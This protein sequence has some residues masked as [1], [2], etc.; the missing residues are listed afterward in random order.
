[1]LGGNPKHPNSRPR[2]ETLRARTNSLSIH[3]IAALC[4]L[5]VVLIAYRLLTLEMIETGGDAVGKWGW[6]RT[7][8]WDY[9]LAKRWNH[10][11]ARLGINGWSLLTQA[12]FGTNPAFYYLPTLFI[13]GLQVVFVFLFC[14]RCGGLMAAVL[15]CLLLIFHPQMIRSGVQLLPAAFSG[16]YIMATI[17]FLC[18]CFDPPSGGFAANRTIAALFFFAAYL[19]KVTNLF[20]LP[21]FVIAVW[22]ARRDFRD[23]VKFLGLLFAL[24][25]AEWFF[26][27]IVVGEYPLGRASIASGYGSAIDRAQARMI[28]ESLETTMLDLFVERYSVSKLGG[29]LEAALFYTGLLAAGV[30]I[31][32]SWRIDNA[33]S[34]VAWACIVFVL[35][36]GLLIGKVDPLTPA[37]GFHRRY[38][39]VLIPLMSA[40]IAILAVDLLDLAKRRFAQA[41]IGSLLQTVVTA[42]LV[43]AAVALISV[44]IGTSRHRLVQSIDDHPVVALQRHRA[45]VDEALSACRPFVSTDYKAEN[46]VR[47]LY[48]DRY[49]RLDSHLTEREE[50]H[51]IML[52]DDCY[53]QLPDLAAQAVAQ[54]SEGIIDVVRISRYDADGR[55]HL[56]IEKDRLDIGE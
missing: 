25:L 53:E 38:L 3:E 55:R 27:S 32:R 46:A 49:R 23:V 17:Y 22:M 51:S 44:E 11:F 54:Q 8:S 41:R 12:V 2:F 9:V 7:L 4:G 19:T 28:A 10:H 30:M 20:F 33:R 36:I 47:R 45:I 39:A 15:A 35:V 42:S 48:L 52:T 6:A 29:H 26:Y 1:M 21:V 18:R 34:L 5:L 14:R 16:A 37:L 56:T 50:I 40:L 31:L 13:S 24:F 43:L